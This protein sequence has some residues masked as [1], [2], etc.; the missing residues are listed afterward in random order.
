MVK[1]GGRLFDPRYVKFERE[2]PSIVGLTRN[3][4]DMD[5]PLLTAL[6]DEEW[7]E[8]VAE[9]KATLTDAV[10]ED[11][12]QHLPA[13][14]YA[15]VGEEITE[16]LKI[17]RDSLHQ[18]AASFYEIVARHA[19]VHFT[20]NDEL[21]VVER[22]T[23]GS[24][25]VTASERSG[26]STLSG[27][28]YYSRTFRPG[29]T[30]DVRIYSHGGDDVFRLTGAGSDAVRLRLMGGGGTDEVEVVAGANVARVE[31][32]DDEDTDR[33]SPEGAVG[34]RAF[35]PGRRLYWPGVGT[36]A[37]TPDFGGRTNPIGIL[38]F[39]THSGLLVGLGVARTGY[40]FSEDPYRYRLS[41]EVGWATYRSRPAARIDYELLDS[42]KGLRLE[43][44]GLS[45]PLE[46]LRYHGFG[47]ETVDTEPSRFYDP[48]HVTY[49]LE[50]MLHY[51]LS[52]AFSVGLGAA[53]RHTDSDTTG[54]SLLAQ[55]RPYGSGSFAEWGVLSEISFDTRDNAV[56]PTSGVA[57][58]LGG[59]YYPEML[60]VA[61][62]YS[63]VHGE[64][65]AYLSPAGSS[66]PT[67]AVRA[68]GRK[69]FGPYP[70]SNGA[71]LGGRDDL[72]GLPEQRYLGDAVVYGGAEVRM[73]FF[74]SRYLLPV[75]FGGLAF[76]DVGRVFLD[77]EDSDSWRTG[78][79]GGLSIS[80]DVA[81]Y[82]QLADMR[83]VIS[84][85]RSTGE[86]SWYF[87]THYAF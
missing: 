3:A 36:G 19:D 38:G 31:F 62:S 70:F 64:V 82:G 59:S 33:V 77:G 26:N 37:G 85:G 69:V 5:R 61:T 58:T 30:E 6:E 74:H 55:D 39:S 86:D 79:G 23:D 46:L 42:K 66:S 78:Y 24:V 43:A 48:R 11:A 13:S 44:E 71:T 63:D 45:S 41:G 40:G 27:D 65:S 75:K 67:L 35:R 49:Q 14:H 50:S 2:Y 4:W 20:D 16:I 81:E 57:V 83:F 28:P 12:V 21:V 10:I 76:L 73:H 15:A 8:V 53:I 17:R 56:T 9:L 22:L 60:D 68:G 54:A 34:I 72:R 29:R 32:Y 7:D 47:N 84:Y 18:A 25:R 87:S 52:P 51:S 80:P 1:A